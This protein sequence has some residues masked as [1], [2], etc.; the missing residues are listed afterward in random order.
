MVEVKPL[1][2]GLDIRTATLKFTLQEAWKP[3]VVYRHFHQSKPGTG[4]VLL[5]VS[6]FPW[7]GF[8]AYS[9]KSPEVSNPH[10]LD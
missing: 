2:I 9:S 8:L 10:Q 7:E 1:V 5:T 3:S 6:I 4:V